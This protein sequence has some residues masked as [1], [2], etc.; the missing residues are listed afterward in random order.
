M[1]Q[2]W[3]T[4]EYKIGIQL[5]FIVINVAKCDN[6]LKRARELVICWRKSWF[7]KIVTLCPPKWV[8]L[9]VRTASLPI[10]TVKFPV[11][12][13]IS[14]PKPHEASTRKQIELIDNNS[15]FHQPVNTYL[16]DYFLKQILAISLRF[17]VKLRQK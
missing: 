8:T 16:S 15:S 6:S 4:L 5:L 7:R 1:I 2:N 3:S 12:S 9:Q 10:G 14:G 11:V 13:A 17:Q